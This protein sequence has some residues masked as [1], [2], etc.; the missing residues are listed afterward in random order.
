MLR[1]VALLSWTAFLLLPALAQAEP[2]TEEIDRW[3]ADLESSQFAERE[4]ASQKLVEAGQ[5]ALDAVAE[6]AASGGAE[7]SKR[8]LD[9]LRQQFDSDDEALKAAAKAKL[10]SLA[11][12]DNARVARRAKAVL[13]PPQVAQ[14]APGG[15]NIQIFPGPPGGIQIQGGGI[16][17]IGGAPA[18]RGMRVQVGNGTR[19]IQVTEG[20]KKIEIADDGKG[21][22]IKIKV[23]EKVEGKDKT[24]EYEAKDVD[25][26]KKKHPEG[27]KLF[28]KYAKGNAAIQ[29]QAIPIQP[30]QL[31]A[32]IRP[33][34]AVPVPVPV[35]DESKKKAVEEIEL[36]QKQL[37]QALEELKKLDPNNE[38]QLKNIQEQIEAATKKLEGARE[39]LGE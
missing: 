18:V 30:G 23:T 7:S 32:R 17:I 14:A 20:E 28:E 36:A 35:E 39:K 1:P 31:P 3:V 26:L 27:A 10:E 15:R 4:A 24:T 2:T 37:E 19:N 9:I 33:R 5:S 38:D 29:I 25:E 13:E 21:A 12:S 8:A 11:E 16:R 34:F 22:N 6:V